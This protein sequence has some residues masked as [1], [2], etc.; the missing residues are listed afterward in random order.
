M[1]MMLQGFKE[2]CSMAWILQF[3]E[4]EE[5]S[6]IWTVPVSVLRAGPG[7]ETR[8]ESEWFKLIQTA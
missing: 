5:V 7:Q 4:F 1:K 6:M 3:P 8:S 2:G